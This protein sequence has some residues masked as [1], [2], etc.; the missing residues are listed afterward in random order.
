MKRAAIL[1]VALVGCAPGDPGVF[2]TAVTAPNDQ[3]LY[4]I[5][6]ATLQEGALDVSTPLVQY[7]L[8]VNY[9]NQLIN[10]G[11]SGTMGP[12]RSD[13]NPVHV[14]TA[15]VEL[16]DING[17]ALALDVPNPF[18]V[19]ATGFVPSSTGSMA[20]VGLG[21]I[22]L[23]PQL[24]GESLRDDVGA[25]SDRMVILASF[26]A[27]GTTAG[28]AAIRM[29]EFVWPITLCNGCLTQCARDTDGLPV[30]RASCTP[31]QDQVEFI[32]QICDPAS[33]MSCA[34]GL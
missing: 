34:I 32:P 30:C 6:N 5:A 3:C 28:G 22:Q 26:H 7:T 16:Q 29:P 12:P 31:G 11:E 17:D 9:A 27:I 14:H 10:L 25:G 4:T 33:M 13:P 23:I 1:L 15:E 18:I 19:P 20:G 21:T 24:V 2:V 8:H